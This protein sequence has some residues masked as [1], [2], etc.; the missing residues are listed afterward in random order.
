MAI[1]VKGFHRGCLVADCVLPVS[2]LTGITPAGQRELAVSE[3]RDANHVAMIARARRDD[4]HAETPPRP[5]P[6][7]AVGGPGR[8]GAGA[9]G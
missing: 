1:G 7:G 5:R 6:P 8:R 9:R 2:A 4:G 3:L